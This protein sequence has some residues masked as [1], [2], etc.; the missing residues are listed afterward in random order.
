MFQFEREFMAPEQFTL[1]VPLQYDGAPTTKP[2]SPQ[3]R[4]G[5]QKLMAQLIVHS[6]L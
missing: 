6:E 1:T 2:D 4:M 5:L 3:Y